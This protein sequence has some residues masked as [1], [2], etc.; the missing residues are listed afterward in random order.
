MPDKDNTFPLNDEPSNKN[1]F[2]NAD[3]TVDET[4]DSKS[5]ADKASETTPNDLESFDIDKVDDL[6]NTKKSDTN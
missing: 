4:P 3:E 5:E 2:I 1:E 6:E